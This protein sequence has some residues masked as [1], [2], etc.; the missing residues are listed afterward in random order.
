MVGSGSIILAHAN[1][2]SCA[3]EASLDFDVDILPNQTA[4]RTA[5][6]N[7]INS[8]FTTGE[9][10][11]QVSGIFKSDNGTMVSFEGN[12]LKG[13]KVIINGSL[14]ND[15]KTILNKIKTWQEYYRAN[16]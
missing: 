8:L 4:R 16:Y 6:I 7:G 10:S 13:K 14:G 2:W 5:V 1:G 12:I 3:N 11:E 9:Y 15:F